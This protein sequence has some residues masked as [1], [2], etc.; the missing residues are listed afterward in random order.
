MVFEQES[1][2]KRI[3]D[4]EK[5]LA[6]VLDS[7]L[8]AT[9]GNDLS[10]INGTLGSR[11]AASGDSG[12]V[13]S[14][15]PLIHN[16]TD[17]DEDDVSTGVFDKINIISSM[18]I[19]DHTSTPITL[20]FIQGNV[21][22][23]T[24]IKIT[25]KIGKTVNVESGGNILTSSIITITDKDFYELVKYSEAETGITG[26]AYKIFLT[27]AGGSGGVSFPID[28]P[29]EQRGAVGFST[30]VIDFTQSDRHSVVMELTGDIGLS[31]TN[32][33]TD[34]LQLTSIKLKQDG[35]GGHALTGFSQPVVNEQVIIDAV[36]NNNAPNGFVSFVIEWEDNAF[37]AYLKTGNNIITGG[38]DEPIILGINTL[39]PQ[40]LPT[41]TEISWDTKNPQHIVLDRAVEF[42]FTNLP[43]NGSYE[44]ILVIIDIDG[45]G[46]FDSPIWPGSVVNPPVIPT[47]ADQRFS[48]MLYTINAGA[49]VTHATSVGSST[50]GEFFGP[51]TAN[52]DAGVNSLVNAAAV[53]YVDTLG[54]PRGTLAGDNGAAALRLALAT[55]GKL[56]ISDVITDILEIDD[57][58][59]LKILGSHVINMSK[60]IINTIGSLEFDRLET[61]T[62]ITADTIGYDFVEQALKY[63]VA[64]TTDIHKFQAA[65]E[66]LAAISR[67]GSNAGLLT[68]TAVTASLLQATETIFLNTFNNTGL[69]DGEIWRD[70]ADGK[71]KFRE[72]GATLDLGGDL[73]KISA[74]DSFI[75]IIDAAT[76]FASFV[77]DGITIATMQNNR[78]DFQET[79]LFGIEQINMN[80]NAANLISS[81][82]ASASG[83]LLNIFSTS[84]FYDIKFNS[85]DAFHVDN[86]RT[87]ILSTS[88]NT[89]AVE[90]SLFRDDP[91][92]LDNTDL[93]VIKFDGR[94]TAA[95]FITYGIFGTGMVDVTDGVET[96]VLVG[97]ILDAGILVQQFRL[98]SGALTIR[99]F[100]SVAAEKAILKLVKEDATPSGG[101]I[102]ASVDYIL[103][104]VSEIIYT[105]TRAEIR[106]ATDAGRYYISVRADNSSLVDAIEIIGDDNNLLSFMN[107]NSRISSDIVFGVESGSTDLKI[108]PQVNSLGIVVQDN[109]G[110]TV[111]SAG[112]L[113]SPHV[114]S[115]ST[116]ISAL[117]ALFGNHKGNKGFIEIASTLT[118]FVKQ[119][120][121]NWG[122]V[123][124]VYNAIT[125]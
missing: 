15:Q 56:I 104:D 2:R 107:I 26:G 52:H 3:S 94:N 119:D 38:I 44:G 113:A 16:I 74:G 21:K 53:A 93:A 51:W 9:S 87:R 111:G 12:G 45:V 96:G 120:N 58:T 10:L 105:Q 117:D 102:I 32:T 14:N 122:Q 81:L 5:T 118:E 86:L 24:R 42:S 76:G 92:P 35:T 11:N 124:W 125:S 95:E 60:N 71:F 82:T 79:D 48:V 17:V 29:E 97:S 91:S 114:T 73:D 59:G 43:L 89:T 49:T 55:S 37:T 23:G 54:F 66:L 62:P 103:R 70:S 19:I 121:G 40:T 7:E 106:D 1:D 67:I 112:T 108:F 85:V 8:S 69:L 30:Q 99:K 90:L 6:E 34:E 25:P 57:T 13:R 47:T 115:G 31:L 18:A 41:T 27:G 83:L 68:V 63:N 110:F 20:R 88:P 84:Q 123:S 101:D 116:T 64:L 39:I 109:V 72:N 50:G 36:N 61:F 46:G 78:M 28:F 75:Q 98:E 77:F 22:D 100:S 65:G 80:D 4:L 33:T